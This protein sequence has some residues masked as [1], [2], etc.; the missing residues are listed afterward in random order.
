MGRVFSFENT[1]RCAASTAESVKQLKLS[2]AGR[3]VHD[4]L[5]FRFPDAFDAEKPVKAIFLA[6]RMK[7]NEFDEPAPPPHFNPVRPSALAPSSGLW[8]QIII[9]KPADGSSGEVLPFS[10]F[11]SFLPA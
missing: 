1:I 6:I 4:A 10:V 7:V 9:A 11:F 3:A 2:T 8:K 5:C